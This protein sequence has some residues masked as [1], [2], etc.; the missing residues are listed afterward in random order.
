MRRVLITVSRSWSDW[1]RMRGALREVWSP[2]TVLV[3]G[4]APRGDMD[5]ERIWVSWG[6]PVERWPADWSRGRSA[7]FARNAEMVASGPDMCLAFIRDGSAGATHTANLAT[8]AGIRTRTFFDPESVP[9]HRCGNC[10]TPSLSPECSPG[11]TRDP[12]GSA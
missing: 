3:H 8:K 4:A 11:C 2:D 5:A 9:A 12:W 6:G 1:E 10:G 7:G